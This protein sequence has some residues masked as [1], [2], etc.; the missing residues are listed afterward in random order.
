MNTKPHK[1]NKHPS[2]HLSILMFFVF[3]FSQREK[4]VLNNISFSLYNKKSAVLNLDCR[5]YFFFLL[6]FIV[7]VWMSVFCIVS[8]LKKNNIT[9][10]AS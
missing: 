6:G 2:G 1:E 10:H 9:K 4:K 3:F 8:M 7:V 5:N